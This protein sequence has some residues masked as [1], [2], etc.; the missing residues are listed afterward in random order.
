MEQLHDATGFDAYGAIAKR[1]D[2]A[3][4]KTKVNVKQ[5][6]S[7]IVG[8]PADS[9]IVRHLMTAL[10]VLSVLGGVNAMAA[11]PVANPS[12]SAPDIRL[13]TL[14]CGLTE[15]KDADVFSD[16]G[17]YEGKPLALPTPCYLIQ[18]GQQWLLWDTGLSDKI[19][20][21]PNGVLEK[22]GGR[23]TVKR[24]LAAQ[25]A[26]LK[27][28]P[29]DVHY[30]GLSHLHFDHAGNI[31]LFPTSTFLV[32]AAEVT[33]A[34]AKPTP[35]GIDL[36][37]IAPLAKA[38]VTAVDEDYDVF[39]DGTVKML[40][41]P[42]HTRGHRSLIVKLPKSGILLITGDLYHTRQN[43]E[44]GLVPHLNDRADTL[45]SME[46]F[47]KIKTNTNARVI[48]QHAP[49]DFAAMPAFPKYLD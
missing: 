21:Q 46:R 6:R 13:Y 23:F 4:S 24:T 34:H 45:A 10:A 30:V 29:S 17:E 49:E 19:A 41:T 11:Q 3:P 40:K 28:K 38:K 15:F 33:A 9:R 31:A 35:F 2:A 44:K 8:K 37:Q 18:H 42:G 20:A 36:A 5:I 14:D 1:K 25:L 16:T 39:G 22:F 26:Q 48:I 12:G 43:Y 32:A 7:N 27:L 47:A